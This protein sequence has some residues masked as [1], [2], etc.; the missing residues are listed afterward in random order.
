M[1][2]NLLDL[3]W[4]N[5]E[6]TDKERCVISIEE[7]CKNARN[8]SDFIG[9]G[10][11]KV[12][13][14]KFLLGLVHGAL[15]GPKDFEEW[16]S[17][18]EEE[19]LSKVWEV[20]S[21][22]RDCFNM[23]SD[24]FYLFHKKGVVMDEKTEYS[25][26]FFD[27][28]K[29]NN[30]PDIM[31]HDSVIES[32]PFPEFFLGLITKNQFDTESPRKS[33]ELYGQ[34]FESPED[35]K[36]REKGK[37]VAK[38]M[39][40]SKKGC[41]YNKINAFIISDNIEK[42]I[43]ANL[44][45]KDLIN[46]SMNGLEFGQ[47]F[48]RGEIKE[49]NDKL[50]CETY[51]STLTPV[52][53]FISLPE[54]SEDFSKVNAVGFAGNNIVFDDFQDPYCIFNLNKLKE[55]PKPKKDNTMDGKSLKF[56]DNK[57]F[58]YN[59]KNIFLEFFIN[60]EKECNSTIFKNVE[61]IVQHNLLENV[62]FMFYG[63]MGDKNKAKTESI[64][65]YYTTC[66]VEELRSNEFFKKFVCTVELCEHLV[67]N[68]SSACLYYKYK[69]PN[70]EIKLNEKIKRVISNKFY[71]MAWARIKSKNLE[72]EELCRTESTE[73]IAKR[74]R[75][76]LYAYY[77]E[78]CPAEVNPKNHYEG[79]NQLSQYNRITMSYNNQNEQDNKKDTK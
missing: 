37:K 15:D 69:Q 62:G 52:N 74:I 71:K 54:N 61:Q 2:K 8:Y 23:S 30:S 17:Y 39:P 12:A 10:H 35:K 72:I 3:K 48:W 64:A 60:N 63:M 20:I 31:S 77:D 29:A 79:K 66:D 28:M 73:N 5:V 56:D 33:P 68:F 25:K 49:L 6:N 36:N 24:T 14:I 55:P 34:R 22:E 38:S 46:E 53:Y 51:L 43:W 65:E 11:H 21:A 40:R 7:F 1:R 45:N 58:N 57:D 18:Y 27:T 26:L 50:F 75:S 32:M 16:A 59:V 76:I 13:T 42:T 70:K 41:S 19:F 78:I 47:P 4:I 67:R 9:Q 44:I